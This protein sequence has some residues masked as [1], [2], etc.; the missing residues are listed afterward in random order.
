[1]C[2]KE[3]ITN[4][5]YG[6]LD[7]GVTE[8][9]SLSPHPDDDQL[10]RWMIPHYDDTDFERN[11][12]AMATE[13]RWLRAEYA[14]LSAAVQHLAERQAWLITPISPE[15]EGWAAMLHRSEF[16]HCHATDLT[17]RCGDGC[18]DP[19]NL[20]ADDAVAFVACGVPMPDM[21]DWVME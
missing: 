2:K 11:I 16:C 6:R 3:E 8:Q 9:D 4:S 5:R 12:A 20:T 17:L 18:C 7:D 14:G 13:L 21:E 10:N 1:M 19:D 15:H